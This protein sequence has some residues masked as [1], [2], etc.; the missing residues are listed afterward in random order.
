MKPTSILVTYA[1]SM[2]LLIS[3]VITPINSQLGVNAKEPTII[4]NSNSKS[5]IL[6]ESKSNY[7]TPDNSSQIWNLNHTQIRQPDPFN[8]ESRI[9]SNTS[10]T[11]GIESTT[12]YIYHEPIEIND[13]GD[14]FTQGWPGNGTEAN[15]FRISG[16]SIYTDDTCINISNVDVFFVVSNSWLLNFGEWYPSYS[17]Y[18]SNGIALYNTS[19]GVIESCRISNKSYGIFL[20]NSANCSI[21]SNIFERNFYDLYTEESASCSVSNNTFDGYDMSNT[22]S[23]HLFL[24]ESFNFSSN[25]YK[26]FRGFWSDIEVSIYLRN[27]TRLIFANSHFFNLSNGIYSNYSSHIL[28]ENCTFTE[29]DSVG[30]FSQCSNIE[31]RNSTYHGRYEG[32]LF[33]SSFNCIISNCTITSGSRYTISFVNSYDCAIENTILKGQGIEIG[34]YELSKFDF[35]IENVT[36]DGKLVGLFHGISSI[37]LDCFQYNQIFLANCSDVGLLGWGLSNL[38]GGI[39]IWSSEGIRI[40]D[41]ILKQ[42]TMNLSN[43]SLVSDVTLSDGDGGISVSSCSD[44]DFENI[45]K[46]RGWGRFEIYDS[47]RIAITSS[48]IK[49]GFTTILRAAIRVRYSMLIQIEDCNLRNGGIGIHGDKL[50]HWT[51]IITN[52]TLDDKPLG[53]FNN[54]K[55]LTIDGSIYGQLIFVNSEDITLQN[56]G[57]TQVSYGFQ[58]AFSSDCKILDVVASHNSD[59]GEHL[60]SCESVIIE[61]LTYDS[62]WDSFRIS[63]S[64]NITVRDS[65]FEINGIGIEISQ[66][67]W[68]CTVIGSTFTTLVGIAIYSSGS[69]IVSSNRIRGGFQ[70]INLNDA[71]SIVI[72]KNSIIDSW[73][74]I[75]MWQ[76]SDCVISQNSIYPR[77]Q[78]IDV[79]NGNR[80]RYTGNRIIGGSSAGVTLDSEVE[81]ILTYNEIVGAGAAAIYLGTGSFNSIYG[82]LFYVNAHI[83]AVDHGSEN[84]WDDGSGI[85]NCWGLAEVDGPRIIEGDAGSVDHY[86]IHADS[87]DVDYPV[88]SSPADIILH[89][90]ETEP[91]IRWIVWSTPGT[92]EVYIDN[93]LNEVGN[94]S[95][96]GPFILELVNYGNG[97]HTYTL[98]ISDANRMNSSDSVIVQFPVVQS[99]I[100]VTFMIQIAAACAGVLVII[101]LVVVDL[102]KKRRT[103]IPRISIVN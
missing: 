72:T 6:S 91:E 67:S 43:N 51:H 49:T 18:L 44:L 71:H 57:L 77:N 48:Q 75:N 94:W 56:V 39:M 20:D 63:A 95:E 29:I 16:L 27:S 2:V 92:Y 37:E 8:S 34:F 46:T 21:N 68:N 30:Q 78:G 28:I 53:Y 98:L 60:I 55:D 13:N 5:V 36:L 26:N 88:I 65:Y 45:T 23:V 103:K 89:G 24:S 86:P 50:E 102:Q 81:A 47:Q 83:Y 69:C 100:D 62:R 70:G 42:L 87:I 84:Q 15:P 54:E 38:A 76:S 52:V 90:N 101:G 64:F 93:V 96:S 22:I 35:R 82:N 17:D 32:I 12:I 80:N 97:N 40:H 25:I 1:I 85:G 61:R 19:N 31:L 4:S 33:S 11:A 3:L 66:G 9:V 73:V 10:K 7:R 99:P 74:G 14:F 79:Q 41:L 58:F 59:Y